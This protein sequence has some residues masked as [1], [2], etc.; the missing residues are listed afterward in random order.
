MS[1]VI[2]AT[3]VL[4]GLLAGLL[5][6][7]VMK[8]GGYGLKRDII[9]G[10]V[11]GIGGGWIFRAFGVFPG[12][13][14]VVVAVVAFIGA[15]IPIVAQRKFWPTESV[16]EERADRWWRWGLG[17]ALVA[18]TG[19]MVLGPA[20]QPAATAAVIDD[21]TY[22][23]T[24]AAMKVKAGI[25]TGDITEMKVTE[26]VEQGSGRVV[27]A[28]KLTARLVLKNSSANQTVRLVAGTI[29]YIDVLG[30]PI[31]LEDARTEPTLKFSTYGSDRLDP[32]QE[33]SQSLDVDFPAEALKAKKLKEIRLE[34]AYIPSPYH[35][36]TINFIVSVGGQ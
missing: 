35:E 12:A 23:V 22:T 30:Q 31:K 18:V 3:W 21:K 28:A 14:L 34:L 27:S 6:G 1:F 29:Q 33:A 20:P 17:A 19:W 2:F 5:A 9:L 32:G 11:G 13:G 26:R 4:V 7:L 24:P 36:E 15:A 10:L 16:G 8:P 25:V